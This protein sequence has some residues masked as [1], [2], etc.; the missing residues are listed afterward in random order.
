MWW[1]LTPVPLFQQLFLLSGKN[2][3]SFHLFGWSFPI[4]HHRH[5]V[6]VAIP[7]SPWFFFSEP[8]LANQDVTFLPICCWMPDG[9]STNALVLRCLQ[10]LAVCWFGKLS[11]ISLPRTINFKFRLQ[12]HHRNITSHSM[13]NLVFHRLGKMIVLPIITTSLIH[14][15]LKGWENVLFELESEGL[16]TIQPRLRKSFPQMLPTFS[17]VTPLRPTRKHVLAWARVSTFFC[18]AG[19]DKEWHRLHT[20]NC[21][22]IRRTARESQPKSYPGLS[23]PSRFGKE[24]DEQDNRSTRR[25]H[26][27]LLYVLWDLPSDL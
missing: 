9:F 19:K 17:L 12:P 1:T 25:A 10:P 8:D 14:I 27:F 21:I 20:Y 2:F 23:M 7:N 24:R 3:D 11:L 18:F 15:L 22:F 16:N 13:K 26:L 4:Q 5:T 6:V